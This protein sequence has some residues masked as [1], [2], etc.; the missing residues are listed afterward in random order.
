[1]RNPWSIVDSREPG[2]TSDIAS[3]MT[4]SSS[5]IA[6]SNCCASTQFFRSFRP[7]THAPGIGVARQRWRRPR[8]ISPS[9][10][11]SIRVV[12]RRDG[13]TRGR[14]T[15]RA[16]DGR[17]AQARPSP[18]RAIARGAGNANA[19]DIVS[20]ASGVRATRLSRA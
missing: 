8:R 19:R 1:M 20:V 12:G 16:A 7:L 10:S 15:A 14:R 3:A 6:R 4:K 2:F 9:S 13:A 17:I 11:S 5:S 18:R